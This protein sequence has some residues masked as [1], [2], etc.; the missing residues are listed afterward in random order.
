MLLL[1]LTNHF[2]Y[3]ADK[4]LNQKYPQSFILPNTVF[5]ISIQQLYTTTF[6]MCALLPFSWTSVEH[7][8]IDSTLKNVSCS[9][10]SFLLVCQ[11]LSLPPPPAVIATRLSLREKTCEAKSCL[12]SFSFKK[13]NKKRNQ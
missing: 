3:F 13:G 4:I 6:L 7:N 11:R 2:F 1:S 8:N 10:F 5:A 9:N 12:C